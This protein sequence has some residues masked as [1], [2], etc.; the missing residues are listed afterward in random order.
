MELSN[1]IEMMWKESVER[2]ARPAAMT[3]KELEGVVASRLKKE[4]KTVS[5]FVWAA[6]VYQIVLYSF[7]A[8]T[9]V[10]AWGDWRVV[11]LCVA[12]AALYVP[13]TAALIQRVKAMFG[14]QADGSRFGADVLQR[15]EGEYARLVD[16]FRFK[17]RMDWFGLPTSCAIIVLVTFT[18]F[19]PGGVARNP[20]AAVVVFA[21]WVGMSVAAVRTENRKRF[22]TPLRHLEEVL[23]D[24]RNG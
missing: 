13:L 16:F 8:H 12:G 21:V 24:L 19:V 18:L 4:F 15:V 20:V 23:T 3:G 11:G 6:I 2:E 9:A 7:V 10:R 1:S 5:Q 17:K 22:V 14:R